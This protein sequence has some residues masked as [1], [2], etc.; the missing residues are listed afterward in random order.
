VC[1][2]TAGDYSWPIYNTV[3]YGY[4]L[5]TRNPCCRRETA[6]CRCKLRYAVF[7]NYRHISSKCCMFITIDGKSSTGVGVSRPR[8]EL[9]FAQHGTNHHPVMVRM[10]HVTNSPPALYSN[11]HNVNTLQGYYDASNGIKTVLAFHSH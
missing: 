1:Y 5:R 8:H 6:R 7:R 3:F 2:R 11:F 9:S 4:N 10:V